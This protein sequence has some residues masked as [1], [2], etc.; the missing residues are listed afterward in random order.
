MYQMDVE[1]HLQAHNYRRSVA[2]SLVRYSAPGETRTPNLLI[3]SCSKP[4]PPPY[5]Q[6]KTAAQDKAAN[7][8]GRPRTGVNE[9]QT[10]PFHAVRW[11]GPAIIVGTLAV[12]D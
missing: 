2:F 1:Q 3:R 12:R 5:A 11:R 10:E 7:T 6:C 8:P 9:T 4:C